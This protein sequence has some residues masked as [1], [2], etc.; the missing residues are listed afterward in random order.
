MDDAFEQRPAAPRPDSPLRSRGE[1]SASEVQTSDL[2]A[3]LEATPD[4][5]VLSNGTRFIYMNRAAAR[6]LGF[7][8]PRGARDVTP[9][10]VVPGSQNAVVARAIDEI[11]AGRPWRGEILLERHDG[12]LVPFSVV[13]FEVGSRAPRQERRY[14]AIFHDLSAQK[15]YELEL[16]SSVFV[17]ELT[18]LANRR[19]F[20]EL[21]GRALR[22]PT[23]RRHR[24]G[25]IAV[26]LDRFKLVNDSMGPAAGNR[27]LIAVA[28]RI[29]LAVRTSDLVARLAADEFIVMCDDAAPDA[30]QIVAER[31]RTA[32]SQPFTIAR[33]EIA[34]TASL[35]IVRATSDRTDPE[36]L[37]QDAITANQQAK[38]QG[39]DRIAF[40]DPVQRLQVA[41]RLSLEQEL[42][43]ALRQNEFELVYQKEVWLSSGDLVC[44]ESLIRWRHPQRGLV[45]P[46]EFIPIAETTGLIVPIGEWVISR[47][48]RQLADWAAMGLRGMS[49]SVNVSPRQIA[50][51]DFPQRLHA[52]LEQESILPNQINLEITE[53]VMSDQSRSFLN[54]IQDLQSAGFTMVM[55][56]F[57]TG[58][59]SLSQLRTL[60]FSV[61]KIDKAFVLHL[62][63][64]PA[65]R[66]L[67]D[68]MIR[69]AHALGRIVVAEGV[70]TEEHAEILTRMSCEMAQG[71]LYGKPLRPEEITAWLLAEREKRKAADPGDAT[72][73]I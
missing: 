59:S 33:R 50:Q 67:V 68:A 14:A 12:A 8:D 71:W 45:P 51:S 17:E 25:L 3:L 13:A 29:Q 32:L 40:F 63:E 57:G 28:D 43:K 18:G 16:E 62:P 21:L 5:V 47:V 39:G 27:L 42:R 23:D 24:I 73:A 9:A 72:P 70:E 58:Y 65:D 37:L 49:V 61:L 38:D 20:L 19:R 53:S 46:D 26:N 7:T 31:I 48:C 36:S 30:L 60:P 1:S 6:F 35:G 52:I 15:A 69:M 10:S 22:E 64:R 41:S 56:D 55:D 2:L 44:L 34:L 11:R 66:Q 4:L 54:R